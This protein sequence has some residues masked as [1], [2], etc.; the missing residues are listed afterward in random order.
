MQRYAFAAT[1]V[2][3]VGLPL[4]VLDAQDGKGPPQATYFPM[5]LGNEWH[6]NIGVGGNFGKA[7]VTVASVE[8]TKDANVVRLDTLIGNGSALTEH[9]RE[10]EQ[11]VFRYRVMGLEADPPVKLL[12]Y[13]EIAKLDKKTTKVT[14]SGK[15]QVGAKE[16]AYTCEASEDV[17]AVA[18]GKF[19]AIKVTI[20]APPGP[21]FDSWFVKDV[22]IVKHAVDGVVSLELQRFVKFKGVAN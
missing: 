1:L 7:V 3:C 5:Q 4:A 16:V 22:G 19:K 15:I 2:V 14:W 17:V 8:K 12:D 9:F 20:K 13:K 6:F 21:T 10:T 11:G 18:A